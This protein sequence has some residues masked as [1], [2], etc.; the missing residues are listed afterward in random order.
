MHNTLLGS[1]FSLLVYNG[2]EFME[3]ALLICSV[4]E[5][6]GVVKEIIIKLTQVSQAQ[7]FVEER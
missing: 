3:N 7:I 2:N 5:E 6:R 1:Y 4:K